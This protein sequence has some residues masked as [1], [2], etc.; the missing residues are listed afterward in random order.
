[1][2]LLGGSVK[3]AEIFQFFSSAGSFSKLVFS[4]Q[5]AVLFK[6]IRHISIT[7]FLIQP[8]FFRV[9]SGL[10][11]ILALR[12]KSSLLCPLDQKGIT[13]ESQAPCE[14]A[15]R[16]KNYNTVMN[17]NLSLSDASAVN[18]MLKCHRNITHGSR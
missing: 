18:Q 7:T 14:H 6:S 13:V 4:R 10:C 1:M 17:H 15:P 8:W 3:I 12:W 5:I 11:S 2:E 9:S 16:R